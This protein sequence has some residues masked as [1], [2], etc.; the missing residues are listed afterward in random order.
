VSAHGDCLGRDRFGGHDPEAHE[1]P[2]EVVTAPRS[3]R[4]LARRHR[5]ALTILVVAIVAVVAIIVV[6]PEVTGLGGTLHHLREGDKSW[7][8]AAVGLEALAIGGYA[9]ILHAVMSWQGTRVGVRASLQI[10]LAGLV[11][12]KLFSAAGA[13]GLA[14]T[15]WALRAAASAA[16]TSLAG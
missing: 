3:M 15:V 5:R 1:P 16:V 10:T 13:G 11:A 7:L 12:T 9:A 6:L 14:L 4:Q 8:A 2:D